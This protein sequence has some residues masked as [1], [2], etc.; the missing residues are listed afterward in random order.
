LDLRF[1]IYVSEAYA[2]QRVFFRPE[3]IR[4]YTKF[5]NLKSKIPC[6]E[7]VVKLALCLGFNLDSVPH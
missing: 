6:Q 2:A 5:F 1:W 7:S 4:T 3:G